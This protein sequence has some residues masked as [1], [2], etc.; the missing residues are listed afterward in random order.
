VSFHLLLLN[1]ELAEPAR[2]K[3]LARQAR[4][5]LCADGGVR[6]AAA[7]GLEPM[8]VIGDMDSRPK[9]LPPWKN[10]TYWCD[11]DENRSDFEKALRF[12]LGAGCES[13]VVAAALGG[14]LDHALVNVALFERYSRKLDLTLFDRG[15][16]R[17]FPPGKYRLPFPKGRAFSLLAWPQA[18][19]VTLKGAAFPL[20]RHRLEPGS[21]GLSNKV[22]GPAA[23][24]VHSGRVWVFEC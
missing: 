22:T 4:G 6:H 19:T 2:V 13:L 11:F 14:R 1:G 20:S 15:L 3:K 10:T 8:C 12:A 21:R 5:V 9:K 23:L 24:E 18:A 16:G 7:L 17:I